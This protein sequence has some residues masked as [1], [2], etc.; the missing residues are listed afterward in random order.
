MGWNN[1]LEN[2]RVCSRVCGDVECEDGW[3]K[4]RNEGKRASDGQ[5]G[6]KWTP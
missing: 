3:I 5:E 2:E 6:S 1:I 4:G